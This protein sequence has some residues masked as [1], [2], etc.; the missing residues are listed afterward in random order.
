MAKSLRK[1]YQL[2]IELKD[3]KPLIWRRFEVENTT[4]L[5]ELHAIIQVIMGWLDCHLHQFIDNNKCYGVLY[6]E[7]DSPDMQDESRFKLNQILKKEKDTIIYEYDFGDGWEHKITLEKILP[8][9]LQAT[10]PLCLKAKGAC[11]PEDVGGVWGYA[12][13]LK[14]L[15]DSDHDEHEQYKEWIGGEFDPMRYDMTAVNEILSHHDIALF[16]ESL[17]EHRE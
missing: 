3:T 8:Y 16:N 15:N 11:P 17:P 7:W 2:K 1:I 4:I 14:A 5:S 10:L 13:F 12:E 6:P 9:S